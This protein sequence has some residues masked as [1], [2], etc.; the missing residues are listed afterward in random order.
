MVIPVTNH[1][2]ERAGGAHWRRAAVNHQNGE[3]V[4]LL[5]L[6]VEGP[7]R[8]DGRAAVT[9][10]RQVEVCGVGGEHEKAN[11]ERAAVQDLSTSTFTQVHDQSTTLS[12]NEALKETEL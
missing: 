1:H 11:G 4:L 10:V 9:E 12:V 5:S 6:A 3:A 7:E 8:S 2:R